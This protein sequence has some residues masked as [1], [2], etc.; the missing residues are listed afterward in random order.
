MVGSVLLLEYLR[1]RLLHQEIGQGGHFD[2]KVE[3]RGPL[4]PDGRHRDEVFP[5]LIAA[6]EAPAHAEEDARA[7]WKK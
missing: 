5:Y 7:D 3:V 1:D 2:W 4:P 6:A